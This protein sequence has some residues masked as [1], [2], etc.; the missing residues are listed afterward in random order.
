MIVS[1]G[2]T[3]DCEIVTSVVST[4]YVYCTIENPVS[5]TSWFKKLKDFRFE[6]AGKDYLGDIL[7]YWERY[8]EKGIS[9]FYSLLV[10]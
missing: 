1:I 4:L 8:F 10:P 7:T 2:G 9:Y 6:F 3:R 5:L